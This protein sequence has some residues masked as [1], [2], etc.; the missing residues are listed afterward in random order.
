M[1][2]KIHLYQQLHQNNANYGASGSKYLSEILLC[3]SFLKPKTILDYGCGKGVLCDL[4]KSLFPN[5]AVYG[6]DPAIA[7]KQT[8]PSHPVDFLICTDVLE[9][10]PEYEYPSVLKQIKSLSN[11]CFFALDHALA[12]AIL[13]TGENAHCTIKPV[14][15]Y[16]RALSS[17]FSA[18]TVLES[19]EAWKSVILTFGVDVQ[20]YRQY[21]SIIHPQPKPSK[22]Q[23]IKYFVLSK[24]LRGK[25][26]E[27]YLKKLS[28]SN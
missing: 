6:Y 12:G 7:G 5:I 25:R 16:E 20:F 21:Y 15:W 26:R 14:C 23:M 28:S 4:I 2:N 27:H 8:L 18:I 1:Q 9:H 19:P 10:I 24:V 13:S 11:N 22:I 3:I 17:Y